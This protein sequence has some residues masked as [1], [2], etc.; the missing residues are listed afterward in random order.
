MKHKQKTHTQTLM[1]IYRYYIYSTFF[2]QIGCFVPA[3]SAQFRICDRLF[4]RIGFED[5]IEQNASSFVVEVKI[6]EIL[7]YLCL[8]NLQVYF[9]DKRNGIYF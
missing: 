4:S 8:T 6:N 9:T 2:F 7:Q 3:K 1:E 5:N